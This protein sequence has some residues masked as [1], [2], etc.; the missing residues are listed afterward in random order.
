MVIN[1][2]LPYDKII[3]RQ[4]AD[5]NLQ[6]QITTNTNATGGCLKTKMVQAGNIASFDSGSVLNVV[7]NPIFIG[8]VR[9]F[10]T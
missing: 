8:I 1:I 3:D 10:I 9:K 6:T 4:N 2:L 7:S 5:T